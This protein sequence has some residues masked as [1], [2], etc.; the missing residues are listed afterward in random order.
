MAGPSTDSP[1]AGVLE[2]LSN[3][4]AGA[5]E[6]AGQSV[7]A[8]HARRRIP[9]SGVHW[10]PG[11]IVAAHHTIQRDE[12]ITISLADG[13]SL[14]ATL[15]GRDPSTDL[16]VLKVDGIT[17]PVARQADATGVRVGALVLALGRP[18]P[19]VTAS[20]GVIS[21]V[22]GEWRTW[23]GGTIDRFVRLDISIYDGFSGGPLVDAA[24]RVL[25]IDTSG[26]SRGAALAIPAATVNR[27]A[28]QLL[29]E[30]RIA[31]GYLGLGMQAVRL[32]AALV[33]RLRLPNDVALMVVSAEPGGPGDKAGVLIGDILVAVDDT[34]VSD[35]AELIAL[36][37]AGKVGTTV[38][39]RLVRG[40]EPTTVSITIA[41]RPSQRSARR[42][43]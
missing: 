26:L 22:G 8:I 18:G 40:G 31:R 23:H 28:D 30:G 21:A 39:A 37:G 16:A 2:S 29:T 35:P 9:S 32:P 20:L 6:R 33:E 41:E 15:A 13:S 5:V 1:S 7:V 11:I 3:D 36:L 19:A 27:V 42:G 25:G 43:R 14:A 17:A 10:R 24:G 12:D 34:N 4:L 38:T